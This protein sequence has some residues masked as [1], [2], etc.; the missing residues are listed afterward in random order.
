ML[1]AID[2]AGE[3]LRINLEKMEVIANN[4]ANIDANGFKKEIAVVLQN[5]TGSLNESETESSHTFGRFEVR[6]VTAFSPG[7]MRYTKQDFDVAIKSK[8]FFSVETPSGTV[9][10]RSGAWMQDGDG[11]LSTLDGGRILDSTNQPIRVAG[12]QLEILGDGSIF[13]NRSPVG[14]LAI[15][16]F[17]TPYQ[18]DRVGNSGFKPRSGAVPTPVETPQVAQGYLELSN[19]NSIESMVEM[20][21]IIHATRNSESAQAIIK[22]QDDLV[23]KTIDM[24]RAG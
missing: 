16:D 15:V 9:Y 10:T 23:G 20:I 12:K 24:G 19:V 13:L 18:L 5:P 22:M 2:V 14:K 17:S 3:S 21:R 6:R 8:G 4:L 1:E 7:P 11:Y